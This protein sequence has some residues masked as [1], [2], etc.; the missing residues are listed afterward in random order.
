MGSDSSAIAVYRTKPETEGYDLNV[1][2]LCADCYPIGDL[3]APLTLKYDARERI[4]YT[5]AE[6]REK[7]GIQFDLQAPEDLVKQNK[8]LTSM[9]WYTPE[10]QS[11]A[12]PITIRLYNSSYVTAIYGVKE[13]PKSP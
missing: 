7:A 13:A 6:Y 9:H 1:Q 11:E 2:S 3:L 8:T 12:N 10:G 4:Q 5:P